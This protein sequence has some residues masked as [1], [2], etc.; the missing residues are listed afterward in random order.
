[1]DLSLEE[2]KE[3]KE[4]SKSVNELAIIGL[5]QD[6]LNGLSKKLIRQRLSVEI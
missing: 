3:M 2:V 6:D 5:S 1:M 4:I